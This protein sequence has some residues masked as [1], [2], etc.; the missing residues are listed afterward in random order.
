MPPKRALSTIT[1]DKSKEAA[2]SKITSNSKKTGI[3]PPPHPD[4]YVSP[5]KKRREELDQFSY[6]AVGTFAGLKDYV[7]YGQPETKKITIYARFLCKELQRFKDAKKAWLYH[8]YDATN[9]PSPEHLNSLYRDKKED[10][11]ANADRDLA[12]VRI[13]DA[14]NGKNGCPQEGDIVKF[15]R[16][17][18]L[19]M[20][21]GKNSQ[22][23][24]RIQDLE[25]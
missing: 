19:Q 13:W 11:K 21:L 24:T 1:E 23:S 14:W 16:F 25:F 6:R 17:T 3:T 10:D 5:A 8:F 15:K 22:L 12:S 4:D 2:S 9:Q 7:N 20:Y 18:G